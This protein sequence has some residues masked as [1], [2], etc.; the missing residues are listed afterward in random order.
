VSDGME[1]VDVWKIRVWL[2]G[3]CGTF[4]LDGM[5]GMCGIC[6]WL[7]GGCGTFAQM[8][9]SG[10]MCGKYV[11]GCVEGV[12]HLS[13]GMEWWMCGKYVCGCVEGV[14]HLC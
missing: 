6:L 14:E 1:W 9:W 13:D 3:G 11:C 8:A 10:G 4:V 7:C 2:C 5:S 12:E